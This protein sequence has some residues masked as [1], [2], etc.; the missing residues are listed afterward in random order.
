M[1]RLIFLGTSS[2]VPDENHQYAQLLLLGRD[3]TLM[4]DCGSNPD[5]RL[6]QLG[7]NSEVPSDLLI[8]HFHPDHSAGLWTFLL[9][10][11]L[12]GR[13]T[14]LTIHG[15]ETTIQSIKTV[16]QLYQWDDWPGLFPV[17]FNP[18]RDEEMFTVLR[19]EEFTVYSSPVQ[20]VIP[21]IGLRIEIRPS[22][23][24]LA[25]SSDTEPCPQLDKLAENA[26]ILI[27]EA[28]GRGAWHSSPAQ[29][30][31]VAQRC[32]ARSL[33]LIHYPTINTDLRQWLEQAQAEFDGP[34]SLAEDNLA[35]DL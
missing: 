11:W 17:E 23:N 2:A 33:Y 24:V 8:T 18:L 26:D 1:A 9:S 20:H 21:N 19:N 32:G 6:R 35:I 34:V 31:Q 14:S 13:K 5:I 28:T 15:L 7:L 10:A 12:L 25:Y 29:A 27:H 4:V 3:H 22:G 16:L 30:G